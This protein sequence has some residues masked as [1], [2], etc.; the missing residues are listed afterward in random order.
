MTPAETV[1]VWALVVQLC[2]GQRREEYTPDA[3]HEVIGDLRFD[4]AVAAVKE[5]GRERAF[6]GTA[7]IWQK[8]QAT[9][10]GRLESAQAQGGLPTVL[11]P[12][13]VARELAERR[14]ITQL[15]MDGD[16]EVRTDEDGTRKLWVHGRKEI[17]R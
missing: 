9:R 7:D 4:H 6:I 14:R 15:V 1:K 10:R 2:P 3:W 5:L 12:D 11:Y 16:A 13:D 8:V 17:G